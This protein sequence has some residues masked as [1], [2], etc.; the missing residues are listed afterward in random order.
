MNCYRRAGT[1]HSSDVQRI[2]PALRTPVRSP[3]RSPATHNT[4][5]ALR[6]G[7]LHSDR[8]TRIPYRGKQRYSSY[9]SLTS[10]LVGGGWL[11]PRPGRFTHGKETRYPL[12]RRL[13]GPQC[14]S[15][16]VWKISPPLGFDPRTVQPVASSYTEYAIP[17]H[18]TAFYYSINCSQGVNSLR[19]EL[20]IMSCSQQRG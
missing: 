20:K 12:Y 13:G 3:T 4:R 14:R 18:S 11:T 16:R 2:R 10:A 7:C 1:V 9:L 15:G 5:A 6:V 19:V 8:K 17:T